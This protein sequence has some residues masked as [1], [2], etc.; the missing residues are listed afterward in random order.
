MSENSNVENP[1]LK[2][3]SGQPWPLEEGQGQASGPEESCCSLGGYPASPE[4][5]TSY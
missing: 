2:L 1:I 5:E 3:H 4:K